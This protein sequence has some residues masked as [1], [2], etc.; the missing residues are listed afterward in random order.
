MW[1]EKYCHYWLMTDKLNPS[2][3]LARISHPIEPSFTVP[4]YSNELNGANWTWW[5]KKMMSWAFHTQAL[6]IQHPFSYLVVFP[7]QSSLSK[8]LEDGVFFDTYNS[9]R[10][11]KEPR[12]SI[13]VPVTA[14]LFDHVQKN[15]LPTEHS[16]YIEYRHPRI[17]FHN[18]WPLNSDKFEELKPHNTQ[19][20]R[21]DLPK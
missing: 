17:Y 1:Q 20:D 18:M 3:K 8:T 4:D 15:P 12:S 2:P 11:V 21:S 14:W 13:N 9:L 19:T 6:L 10:V 16:T 5:S 7:D